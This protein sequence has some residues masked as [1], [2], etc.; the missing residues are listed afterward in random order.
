MSK[1]ILS[2][3][4][5]DRARLEKIFQKAKEMEIMYRCDPSDC[6]SLFGSET[7]RAVLYFFEPSTRT[8]MSS[9]QAL[10]RL[11]FEI[12]YN[13]TSA[14]ISSSAAKGESI[15][16]AFLN[17][18]EINSPDILDIVVLRH[19]E[20]DAAERAAVIA[21]RYNSNIVNAGTGQKEHPTQMLLDLYTIYQKRDGDIDGTKIVI[22]G[23]PQ[24]SRTIHSLIIG[25][26]KNYKIKEIGVCGPTEYF[27]PA[28]VLA[29]IDGRC[30]IINFPTYTQALE[31]QPDFFYVTRP[32]IERYIP[33][34]C[35]ESEKRKKIAELVKKFS[36]LQIDQTLAQ[37]MKEINCFFMHPQPVDSEHF[38][39]ILAE[40]ITHEN[41]LLLKQS[42]NG[43]WVR[44]AAIYDILT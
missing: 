39:E 35:S 43:V 24:A 1:H 40:L 12:V 27:L 8:H 31:W 19:P 42:H 32:Q 38:N 3:T 30:Q 44:M 15:E 37:R 41:S 34:G 5:Y 4:Q 18:Y 6:L 36:F 23:D 25:L 7:R 26:V 10:R 16:N 14:A 29:E 28:D 13:T 11:G 9:E 20:D 2:A 22:G 17:M 21:D 33:S